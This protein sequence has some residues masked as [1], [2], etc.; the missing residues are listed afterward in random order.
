MKDN[1][2]ATARE[3]INAPVSKVWDGLT[4]PDL[5]KKYMMGA[6]VD[7]DWKKGSSIKWKG[8]Y[9]G[10]K[11]EDHGNILEVKPMETLSYTHYSP[12]AGKEDVP[13]NYHTVTVHLAGDENKTSITLEQSKN[14]SEKEKEE[15][16]KNWSLMLNGLKDLLEKK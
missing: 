13:E 6:I 11:Y 9:N 1:L 5:I 16:E 15:S 4:N 2:I 12:L 8:E 14:K 10:K 3:T 7:S